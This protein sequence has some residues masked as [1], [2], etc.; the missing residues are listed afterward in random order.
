MFIM[1]VFISFLSIKAIQLLTQH[2]ATVTANEEKAR[3][4]F[5]LGECYKDLGVTEDAVNVGFIIA[6]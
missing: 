2:V 4:Y 1:Y 5:L 3:V 6:I